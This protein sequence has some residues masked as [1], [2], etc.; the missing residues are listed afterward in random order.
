MPSLRAS[1]HATL[2]RYSV[3]G[4]RTLKTCAHMAGC[5]NTHAARELYMSSSRPSRR[6]RPSPPCGMGDEFH[7]GSS[8][9]RMRSYGVY[10]RTPPD[11]HTIHR[12][13]P[14][15]IVCGPGSPLQFIRVQD[16]ALA[17]RP[18]RSGIQRC[19]RA[20]LCLGL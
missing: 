18:W 12:L 3:S 6:E 5:R 15:A 19:F 14:D 16:S 20:G 10:T 11:V 7:Q 4:S 17:L 8:F 9:T 1:F 13:D 2:S